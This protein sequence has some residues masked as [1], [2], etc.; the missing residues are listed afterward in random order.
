MTEYSS[1]KRAKNIYISGH[2]N[3]EKYQVAE[4]NNISVNIPDRDARRL[5]R[6]IIQEGV[7]FNSIINSISPTIRT[8]KNLFSE[9]KNKYFDLYKKI[10]ETG[11]K[12]SPYVYSKSTLPKEFKKFEKIIYG[13]SNGNNKLTI[14][15]ALLLDSV[16]APATLLSGVRINIAVEI[17]N[18][19][20]EQIKKLDTV[21]DDSNSEIVYK[22]AAEM[23]EQVDPS[24]RNTI[25]LTK[26]C[27]NMKYDSE[28]NC[29]LIYTQ[30]THDPIIVPKIN[31]IKNSDWTLLIIKFN[32]TKDNKVE[33]FV[34]TRKIKADYMVKV[35]TYTRKK[36]R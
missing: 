3:F 27:F 28:N 8:G 29:T 5:E 33:W 14:R 15:M 11:I 9:I 24:Y 32:Y 2:S 25:Q 21:Q 16:A 35:S 4:Y 19:T 36:L 31:L 7:Y 10:A 20:L 26:K 30:Y 13:D 1:V 23:L 22:K 6:F 18:H 34:S 12:I 17:L